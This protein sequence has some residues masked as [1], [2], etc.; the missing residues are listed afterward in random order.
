M[1]RAV[2]SVNAAPITTV[3]SFFFKLLIEILTS[4]TVLLFPFILFTLHVFAVHFVLFTV[5]LYSLFFKQDAV[6]YRVSIKSVR[7]GF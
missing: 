7:F 5:H 6:I 3:H 1:R 2:S 4:L